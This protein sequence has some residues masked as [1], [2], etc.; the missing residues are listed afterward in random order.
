[1]TQ[2]VSRKRHPQAAHAIYQWPSNRKEII[3]SLPERLRELGGGRALL[4]QDIASR[5]PTSFLALF[6]LESY[7]PAHTDRLAA[8]CPTGGFSALTTVPWRSC[9][10]KIPTIHA[11]LAND[12]FRSSRIVHRIPPFGGWALNSPCPVIHPYVTDSFMA[13]D[14]DE[15]GQLTVALPR[16]KRPAKALHES[17]LLY[18]S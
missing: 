10:F 3:I 9:G 4:S 15:N 6:P 18:R 16:D 17:G 13:V 11:R 14:R 12:A 5:L 7:W 1:M 8:P 2:K